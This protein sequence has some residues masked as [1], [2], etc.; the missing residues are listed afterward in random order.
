[1]ALN[2][3]ISVFTH[4]VLFSPYFPLTISS[5]KMSAAL[6][7]ISIYS[8]GLHISKI[9]NLSKLGSKVCWSKV[10]LFLLLPTIASDAVDIPKGPVW[11]SS[12]A[13]SEI[14]VNQNVFE[15]FLK[16]EWKDI[17]VKFLNIYVGVLNHSNSN[18]L[19]GYIKTS[20]AV[21][22]VFRGILGLLYTQICQQPDM[23][24]NISTTIFI[25]VCCL[26][27]IAIVT[28]N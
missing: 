5:T 3:T 12:Q 21:V 16:L 25:Q 9:Q 19:T 23:I 6:W 26:L 15:Y 11:K 2:N 1:M 28:D 18:Q 27:D 17:N 13:S 7:L 8:A 22:Q 10:T 20:E 14:T 4:W 24:S